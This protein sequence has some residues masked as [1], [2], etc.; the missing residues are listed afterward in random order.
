MKPRNKILGLFVLLAATGLLYGAWA[1]VR[2]HRNLVTLNVRN[3]DVRQV[4]TKIEWQTWENILVHKNVQG[5]VTLN[6]RKVPLE[7]VL[8]IIGDQTASRW[9]AIYPLYSSGK[10]LTALK[11]AL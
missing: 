6:V 10:S 11:R 3:M 1:A 2:A 5:K 4:V 7:E 8:K 9:S